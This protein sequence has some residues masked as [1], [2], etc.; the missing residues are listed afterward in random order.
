MEIYTATDIGIG[1]SNNEDRFAVIGNNIFL[2]ADGMG[3]CVAGEV[4]SSMM[5]KC[6]EKLLLLDD[7]DKNQLYD[8]VRAA[9]DAIIEKTEKEPEYKGM[10]TTA[11]IIH[12]LDSK[13]SWAN[14]GDSRCYL[15][16]SGEIKQITTDHTLVAELVAKGSITATE[17]RNHPKRHMLTRAVGAD[18]NI[19]VDFGEFELQKDDII[20]LCTDGV[21]S[22]LDDDEILNSLEKET[23]DDLAAR[24]VKE[25]LSKSS[26]DNITAVV[27]KNSMDNEKGGKADA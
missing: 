16:R 12:C 17:A 2:V 5:V 21:T 20:L 6:A 24:L 3:G 10:G 14:V 9:N 19:E 26:R 1:R 13:V 7:V 11:V 15:V 22:V 8:V 25:A 4:A 18:K 23:S 27:I